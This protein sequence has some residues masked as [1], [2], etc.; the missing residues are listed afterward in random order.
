MHYVRLS[1]I[2]HLGLR[3]EFKVDKSCSDWHHHL[4]ALDGL[5][6]FDNV[7]AFDLSLDEVEEIV[8]KF[9]FCGLERE[10]LQT[11]REGVNLVLALTLAE[12]LD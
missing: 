1:V 7:D 12:L 3:A 10:I 11:K 4:F 8:F 9:F 2:N 5:L 6:L